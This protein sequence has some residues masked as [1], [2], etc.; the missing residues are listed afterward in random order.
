[1]WV[2]PGSNHE[3]GARPA[4]EPPAPKRVSGTGVKGA[5]QARPA[6]RSGV[7]FH[8]SSCPLDRGLDIA[9]QAEQITA[10]VLALDP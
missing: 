1:M 8:I 6:G 3:G 10:V 5:A 2:E 7:A 4:A 9:V